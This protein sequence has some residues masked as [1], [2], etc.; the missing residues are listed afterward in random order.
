MKKF[1]ANIRRERKKQLLTIEQLA[2]KA[3]IT[4]N[5][6]G[7]IERGDSMPS[8]PTVDVIASAFN[9]GID[10]LMGNAENEREYQ[11]VK[12]LAELNGLDPE[13]RERFIEFISTNIRF[14]K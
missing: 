3:G 9:V 4:D 8:L 5:F 6:R 12:S 11:F 1:G 13:K 10:F 2:E 14:F 7:K